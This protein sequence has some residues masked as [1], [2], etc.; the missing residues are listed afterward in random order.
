MPWTACTAAGNAWAAIL[1]IALCAYF[2][3]VCMSCKGT[4]SPVLLPWFGLEATEMCTAV[5]EMLGLELGLGLHTCLLA[6]QAADCWCYMV[7]REL[8]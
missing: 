4:L 3:P 2:A 5:L 1:L 8:C 7:V 6:K